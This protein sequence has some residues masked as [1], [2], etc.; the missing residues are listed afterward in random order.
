MLLCGAGDAFHFAAAV[1]DVVKLPDAL[2]LSRKRDENWIK[3]SRETVMITSKHQFRRLLQ[4]YRCAIGSRSLGHLPY[5]AW[6]CGLSPVVFNRLTLP[7]CEALK[8]I[9]RV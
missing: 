2:R 3:T 9:L 4:G 6:D 5:N 8:I 1:G 7:D